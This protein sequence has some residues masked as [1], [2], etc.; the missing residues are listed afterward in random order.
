MRS[1]ALVDALVALVMVASVATAFG[2]AWRWH[3]RH[4]HALATHAKSLVQR[5]GWSWSPPAYLTTHLVLGL[6]VSIAGLWLFASLAEGVVE[7][8][9][10]T[11]LDVAV[12]DALHAHTTAIGVRLARVLSDIGSPTAMTVLM[13][14]VAIVLWTRRER[15]L[16]ATWIAAFGGGAIL[17][18]LL[19]VL[20][21]R[22]RPTFAA[23]II[24]AHGF[25]FPSGHA[26]GS[27]VGFG[28]L[29]YLAL[30]LAHS[31]GQRLTIIT[32]AI[33]FIVAIG[34]SRL[35]L[36][37]HYLSDVVAG[38]AAGI[39]WLGACLSGAEI[40]APRRSAVNTRG[41]AA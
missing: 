6:L 15:A 14:V 19:K 25:S 27:L 2:L 32:I 39:V 21:H 35:Y 28:V 23:P 26:M 30:R 41:V 7:H 24:I 38:Y 20:F 16:F 13:V 33:A 11:R 9:P 22:P 12:D 34:L 17:D 5:F 40:V 37:V 36:G 4:P 29:A 8:E 18:Q 1:D 10:V 3:Q 31:H